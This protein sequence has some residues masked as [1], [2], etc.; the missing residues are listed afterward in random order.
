VDTPNN[1]LAYQSQVAGGW[2]DY[3]PGTDHLRDLVLFATLKKDEDQ[4]CN[5][6]PRTL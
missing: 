3:V 2:Q 5:T 1:H 6:P 4:P